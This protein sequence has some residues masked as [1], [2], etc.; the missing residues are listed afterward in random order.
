[1]EVCVAQRGGIF[2][3]EG[4]WMG[5]SEE[6]ESFPLTSISLEAVTWSKAEEAEKPE[7]LRSLLSTD[8]MAPV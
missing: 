8:I 7:I 4:E 3:L 2:F 6:K 1:M 5:S